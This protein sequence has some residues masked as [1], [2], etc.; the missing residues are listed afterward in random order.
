MESSMTIS[1][2]LPLELGQ[3]LENLA[4]KIPLG[5]NG[6]IVDALKE[7]LEKRHDNS[8]FLIKEARRQS[9]LA[10]Q[11]DDEGLWEENS[12]DSGWR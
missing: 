12:D 5:T 2:H 4:N 6:I 1:L 7:Y 9:I 3:Q 10:S 8:R 11:H